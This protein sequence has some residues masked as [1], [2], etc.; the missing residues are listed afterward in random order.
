[1]EV[2]GGQVEVWACA[3]VESQGMASMVPA[4]VLQRQ[5]VHEG[6]DVFLHQGN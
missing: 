6:Q 3:S 5:E 2:P 1:M 4:V